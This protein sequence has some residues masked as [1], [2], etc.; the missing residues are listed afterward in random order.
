M[1]E[2]KFC[3]HCKGDP[4]EYV[5]VDGVKDA[6]AIS[7]CEKAVTQYYQGLTKMSPSAEIDLLKLGGVGESQ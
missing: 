3:Q 7:C 6:V 1:I 4:F 2:V 5:L